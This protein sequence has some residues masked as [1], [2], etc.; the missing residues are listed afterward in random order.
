MRSRA[1]SLPCSFC[2]ARR[3]RRH[4]AASCSPLSAER[5]DQAG[6]RFVFFCSH[7]SAFLLLSQSSRRSFNSA[8]EIELYRFDGYLMGFVTDFDVVRNAD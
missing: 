2:L 6:H 3:S 8:H 7:R 4:L 1:V 5:L